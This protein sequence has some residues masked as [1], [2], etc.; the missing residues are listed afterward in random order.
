MSY[1]KLESLSIQK[2]DLTEKIGKLV[3]KEDKF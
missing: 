3:L 1:T 2:L